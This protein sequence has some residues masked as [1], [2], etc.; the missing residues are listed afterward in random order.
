MTR[1][2]PRSTRE[3]RS[4][5]EESRSHLEEDLEE[6]E[7]RFE[8]SLSP[9]HLFTR[10]PLLVSLAGVAFGV[11]VVRKPTLVIRSAGRLATLGAPL[12]LKT[13]FKREGS[14]TAPTASRAENGAGREEG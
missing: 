7:E 1:E 2:R 3:I 8:N 14:P 6:L 4:S 12:L 10:Y 13:I 9:R 5:L 11:L